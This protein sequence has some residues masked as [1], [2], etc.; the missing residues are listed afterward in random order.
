MVLQELDLSG[1]EIS[2]EA[3][4][5]LVASLRHSQ[6]SLRIVRMKN[7]W[8]AESKD[9]VDAMVRQ[10]REHVPALSVEL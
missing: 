5:Q 1:N 10:L 9:A 7:V 2:A 6:P 3:C 8:D 4:A